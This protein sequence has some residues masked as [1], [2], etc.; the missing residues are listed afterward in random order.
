VIGT[1]ARGANDESKSVRLGDADVMRQRRRRRP[2]RGGGADA[3]ALVGEHCTPDSEDA[4][5]FSGFSTDEVNF[6]LQDTDCASR[7]CLSFHF[8]GRMTCPYGQS[9]PGMADPSSPEERF[10]HFAGVSD[11]QHRVA[12]PVGPQCTQRRASQAVF[13]SCRCGGGEPGA[14]YCA[15]PAGTHCV[16][17]VGF[18]D[19]LRDPEH[20]VGDYCI[21]DDADYVVDTPCTPCDREQLD[22]GPIDGG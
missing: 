10:C 19:R 3:G 8:R 17:G 1:I 20:L 11:P 6:G 15:C 14:S 13:C 7:I 12:V 4:E 16:V 18:G 22:C 2:Q 21:R 9:D 5:Y